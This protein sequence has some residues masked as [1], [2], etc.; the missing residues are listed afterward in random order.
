[1]YNVHLLDYE[2]L[3]RGGLT[4]ANQLKTIDENGTQKM[5]RE[6]VHV[7]VFP[8][9]SQPHLTSVI[10]MTTTQVATPTYPL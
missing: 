2:F 1:M 6:Y 3:T 9:F 10:L 8:V 5:P 7:H 4:S